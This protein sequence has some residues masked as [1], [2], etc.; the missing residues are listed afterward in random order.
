[1]K[2][3]ISADKKVELNV[4]KW[5]MLKNGWEYYLEEGKGDVVFGLVLG[6]SD[7]LGYVSLEEVAPY[8]AYKVEGAELNNPNF[9]PA[10]A[11]GYFWKEEA[12]NVN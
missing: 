10:P 8:V 1:M 9:V 6:A 12:E 4:D 7:E 11:V 3:M 5:L 2:K